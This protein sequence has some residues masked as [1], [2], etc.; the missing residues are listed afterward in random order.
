MFLIN[1]VCNQLNKKRYAQL[2]DLFQGIHIII[3]IIKEK[4]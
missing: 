2:Y 1:V 4:I 3:Q